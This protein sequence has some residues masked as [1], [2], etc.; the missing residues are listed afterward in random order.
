MKAMASKILGELAASS[1][2]KKGGSIPAA[3]V[4]LKYMR[5]LVELDVDPIE[6]FMTKDPL[7][8]L[9]SI[10]G[11]SRDELSRLHTATSVTRFKKITITQTEGVDIKQDSSEE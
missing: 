4:A 9:S 1:L 3:D 5:F 11:I 2:S 6:D 8:V 10:T 7:D